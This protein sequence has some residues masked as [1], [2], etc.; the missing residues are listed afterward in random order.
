MDLA[1]IFDFDGT[2]ANSIDAILQLINKLAPRYGF[3]PISQDI[4]NSVRDLSF[5]KACR[6]LHFPL[7]KLPQAI[8]MVLDEYRHII[9]E[10]S[11]C[12]GM[13][14]VIQ[15]LKE[16]GITLGLISSND[17]EYIN[18]FLRNHNL[19]FFDWVEGTKGVLGKHN[20]IQTQIK[21]YNLNHLNT[22]YVGDEVRD[23]K[24]AHRSKVKIISVTWGLHSEKNLL[25]YHPDYLVTK[26]EELLELAQNIKSNSL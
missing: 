13:D 15:K 9:P 24:A 21:K 6:K 7:S 10:L 14:S 5:S 12:P 4:F 25:R 22:L 20:S 8:T 16:E 1:L 19:E 17:S 11:P 18:S 2:V 3:E 23:I 26:P